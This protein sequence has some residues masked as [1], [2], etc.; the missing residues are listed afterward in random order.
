MYVAR[1][2]ISTWQNRGYFIQLRHNSIALRNVAVN[3]WR[4]QVLQLGEV[5]DPGFPPGVRTTILGGEGG[6]SYGFAKFS[7]KLHGIKEFGSLYPTPLDRPM[8]CDLFESDSGVCLFRWIL[9]IFHRTDEN[10]TIV[11]LR[12]S[13]SSHTWIGTQ[14]NET[15][16]P[17]TSHWLEGTYYSN[18]LERDTLDGILIQKITLSGNST[19]LAHT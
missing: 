10:D 13:Q 3:C 19:Q 16:T 8:R 12:E 15:S 14:F 18:A 9:V 4:P 5:A 6:A 7:W 17:L 1:H 2:C 11:T